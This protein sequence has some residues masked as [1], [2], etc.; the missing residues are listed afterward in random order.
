MNNIQLEAG[1]LEHIRAAVAELACGRNHEARRVKP[2]RNCSLI[3]RQ[4]AVTDS[5][6]QTADVLVLDGSEPRSWA[7]ELAR[8]E[9]SNPIK[10]PPADD[11]IDH[12]GSATQNSVTF[13]ER[14]IPD[15]VE[16]HAMTDGVGIASPESRRVRVLH[17][18]RVVVVRGPGP[19]PVQHDL[20]HF[21]LLH[22]HRV[23]VSGA[24]IAG[25]RCADELRVRAAGFAQTG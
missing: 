13:A 6:R 4:I 21:A 22:R 19:M 9:I 15:D 3:R 12:S 10:L 20:A 16:H 14:D 24:V 11:L 23:K 8:L 17:I 7:E 1:T 2:V 5:I 25:Q 18:Q